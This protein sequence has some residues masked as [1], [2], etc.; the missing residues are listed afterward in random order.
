MGI[1]SS[2]SDLD[3]SNPEKLRI[4]SVSPSFGPSKGVPKIGIEK[5]PPPR[6]LFLLNGETTSADCSSAYRSGWLLQLGSVLR[7]GP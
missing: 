5:P 1:T 4:S 2:L 7:S 6:G 3:L